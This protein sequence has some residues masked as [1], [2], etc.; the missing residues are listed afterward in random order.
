MIITTSD[1]A[2]VIDYLGQELNIPKV[3]ISTSV[4]PTL[5]ML[6]V[7]QETKPIIKI[8]LNNVIVNGTQLTIDNYTELLGALEP[9]G[10][11]SVNGFEQYDTFTDFPSEGSTNTIYL[12][13]STGTIYYWNGTE[14]VVL[15][16]SGLTPEQEAKIN[17]IIINGDGNS[18]LANDG[19]YKA[20]SGGSDLPT[21]TNTQFLYN[22]SG[23]PVWQ[24]PM[25]LANINARETTARTIQ[26]SI[27]A[28][29]FLRGTVSYSGTS[30]ATQYP[31]SSLIMYSGRDYQ[32]FNAGFGIINGLTQIDSTIDTALNEIID[33]GSTIQS[34]SELSYKGEVPVQE[35]MIPDG[36]IEIE[37]SNNQLFILNE[38]G[39]SITKDGSPIQ[40]FDFQSG[41][42]INTFQFTDNVTVIN[43]NIGVSDPIYWLSLASIHSVGGSITL[44][45]QSTK[46]IIESKDIPMVNI[47]N[48]NYVQS[49]RPMFVDITFEEQ[50]TG[51]YDWNNRKI[52]QKTIACGALPNNT[53]KNV[54][55]GISSL[56]RVL[57]VDGY[58]YN[59][60]TQVTLPIPYSATTTNDLLSVTTNNTNIII[61]TNADK[62]AYTETYVTLHYTCTNR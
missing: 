14:Y 19:T 52:Y 30:V 59:S 7:F 33:Q 13:V 38:N 11:S 46:T 62:S 44:G 18:Y 29:N 60:G 16:G 15:G 17:S 25:T 20:V 28:T 24:S 41:Q 31:S 48:S 36:T 45:N 2:V 53:T 35:G 32:F 49:S 9:S 42:Q 56:Y 3:Q 12:D 58:T 23:T 10:G 51:R 21:G 54:T 8:E 55:H 6:I 37:F 40:L 26:P 39:V 22:S 43:Q 34:G 4:V 27:L 50:F 61:V 57:H 47:I 5:N 1:N